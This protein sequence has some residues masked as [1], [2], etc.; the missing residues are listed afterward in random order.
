MG[1][2]TNPTGSIT[3]GDTQSASVFIAGAGTAAAPSYTFSGD[4]NTGIYSPGADQVGISAGGTLR[5]AVSTTAINSS[6]PMLVGST[7]LAPL[8]VLDAVNNASNLTI[9]IGSDSAAATR[10]NATNKLANITIPHYLAAQAPASMIRGTTT[11]STNVTEIGGG[12]SV[13]NAATQ[14]TFYT[15]ANNTTMTGTARAHIASG[16]GSFFYNPMMVGSSSVAPDGTLHAFTATAGSVTASG[17]ADEIVAENSGSGGMSI[18][19]PDAS[20]SNLYFG[21]PASNLGAKIRWNYNNSLFEMGTS[22]AGASLALQGD[23]AV[24]NLTLSGAAGSELATF[25]KAVTIGGVLGINNTVA[26]AV[27]VAST[28]KVTILIGATTY[29]LLA[30][31]VA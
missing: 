11:T 31:N 16:G 26:A 24:T 3:T 13:A 5:F 15:A 4:L 30:T 14:V 9:V 19:V 7:A 28:H 21:S 6:L 29:Y 23:A 27:A 10:T 22:K 1:T 2:I 20:N 25:V 18:L 12:S 17:V 8:G